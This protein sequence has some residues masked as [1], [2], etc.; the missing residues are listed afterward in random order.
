MTRGGGGGGG[1]GG[2]SD[3]SF[4]VLNEEPKR[5]RGGSGGTA[6]SHTDEKR[7][8]EGEEGKALPIV[9][10]P[11]SAARTYSR[12]PPPTLV[13]P[14]AD[15]ASIMDPAFGEEISTSTGT[16]VTVPEQTLSNA[17]YNKHE[18]HGNTIRHSENCEH[19]P[20]NLNRASHSTPAG[21][22]HP[23]STPGSFIQRNSNYK[24]TLSFM[25]SNSNHKSA[26][27]SFFASIP[28]ALDSRE[29]CCEDCIDGR[30]MYRT[31]VGDGEASSS[32]SSP[33]AV[34]A[35]SSR[36]SPRS[37][38][39]SELLVARIGSL[40]SWSSA[41]RASPSPLGRLS[42]VRYDRAR[43]TLESLDDLVTRESSRVREAG[44]SA[45]Q[46]E[47]TPLTSSPFAAVAKKEAFDFGFQRRS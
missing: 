42:S 6:G 7:G 2:G 34:A 5:I 16:H 43:G 17:T 47:V 3:R 45:I 25:P 46:S 26:A 13:S 39:Q 21:T 8:G 23:D 9:S 24:S 36:E 32:S 30:E 12:P 44:E 31:L 18:Q 28:I 4:V 40:S 20:N 37:D 15:R 27:S 22:T 29:G 10:H 11:D 41:E 1:G 35:P 19:H 14:F 33:P 38:V